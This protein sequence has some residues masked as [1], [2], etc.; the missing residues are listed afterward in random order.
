[1]FDSEGG[2]GEGHW[3]QTGDDRWVVKAQ[4]V[5]RDGTATSATQT[6]TR[7]NKDA[8]KFSS[9]DRVVGGQFAPDIDEIILVR[10]PPGPGGGANRATPA[11]TPASVIAPR[12]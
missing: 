12:P 6:I 2:Q 7:V 11:P 8:M 1:A 3:T 4:G 9:T 5:L 10:K